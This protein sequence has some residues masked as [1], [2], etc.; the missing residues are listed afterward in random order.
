MWVT[1]N[2]ED[3]FSSPYMHLP[4]SVKKDELKDYIILG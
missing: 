2:V 3:I 4:Y 1:D